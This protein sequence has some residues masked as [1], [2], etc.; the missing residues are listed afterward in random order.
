MPTTPPPMIITVA[1]AHAGHAAEQDAAAA[2]RLLEHEGPGLR[3]DLA[4]DLAHR[5]QQRQPA[6]RVLDG[7]VG[8]AG[9]ARVAQARASSGVRREV[10]VGEE[11]LARRAAARPPPAA[12]PS[13]SGPCP[14]RRTPPRRRA[15]CARPAPRTASSSIELPSP[16]PDWIST[17]WPRSVSSRH[18]GRGER[19]AVLVRLDLGRDAD[20]HAAHRG[21]ARPSDSAITRTRRAAPA[22]GTGPRARCSARAAA[23]RAR[24]SAR[25]RAAAPPRRPGAGRDDAAAEAPLLARPVTARTRP[26]RP[27]VARRPRPRGRTRCSADGGHVPRAVRAAPASGGRAR[28]LAQPLEQRG[29]QRQ[30][31]ARLAAAEA[32]AEGAQLGVQRVDRLRRVR[33]ARRSRPRRRL[34]SGSIS[35]RRRRRAATTGASV[36]S[37]ISVRSA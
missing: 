21:S 6:V 18:A 34:D 24:R 30:P 37:S 22:R 17:S 9:R 3:G 13:P 4:G 28:Q 12:A 27:A 16:A 8:D 36:S 33:S 32:V 26:V 10:Q 35:T 15:R 20:L 1:A 29:R 11:H 31:E 25:A 7:L 23:R 5:R 14:P 2:D 19:D